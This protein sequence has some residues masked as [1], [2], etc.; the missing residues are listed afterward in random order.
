VGDQGQPGTTRYRAFGDIV[1]RGA[2][3]DQTLS[4]R[5]ERDT[6]A[7]LLAV[8]AP[9]SADR[10]L[11]E[12]WEGEGALGSLQAVVSRLRN[13]LEP[14][15]AARGENRCLVSTSAGYAIRADVADVDVW[16]FEDLAQ[17][18]VAGGDPT[19]SLRLHEE[20]EGL[21]TGTPYADCTSDAVV[22]ARARL[23]ELRASAAERAAH[24][25]LDLGRPEQVGLLLAPLAAEHPFRERLFALLALAH[26]RCGRQSEALATLRDLRTRLAD[27]LGVDPTPEV[28]RLETDLLQHSPAL[29]GPAPAP[30]PRSTPTTST[31]VASAAGPDELIG[32]DA[33][34][35]RV[36]DLLG[37]LPGGGQVVSVLGEPGI[38]K[39]RLVQEVLARAGE[40]GVTGV[41]GQCHQGDVAPALWPW[42][43]VVRALAPHAEGTDPL[44]QP[45]LDGAPVDTGSGSLRLFDAVVGLLESTA[46]S[47][48]GLVVVLEDLH[49]ADVT[50]LQLLAHVTEAP[51]TAPLLL[52]VTRRSTEEHGSDQMLVT[53]AALARAG[54]ER[55]R[56]DGLARDDVG[57]LLGRLLGRSPDDLPPTLVSTVDEAT[58]GNAFF[59]HEYARL[60]QALG[61]TDE[62]D[63]VGDLPVPEGVRDVIGQRVD[64]LPQPTR[65]LLRA[66]AVLGRDIEPQD[67]AALADQSLDEALDHLDLALA[68]G[69][70]EERRDGYTFAHALTREALYADLSAARRIRLHAKAADVLAARVGD[71]PDAAADIAHH[72]LLAVP[73]G[74]DRARTAFTS[75]GHAARV[76]LARQAPV[77]SRA[78]WLQARGVAEDL[79]LEDERLHAMLGV[80]RS[81]VRMGTFTEAPGL[82]KELAREARR[83]GHW[84]LVAAAAATFQQAGPWTWRVHGRKDEELIEVFT[85]ALDHVT[86]AAD[87][88][89]LCATLTIEHQF[90]WD[91]PTSDAYAARAI[92]AARASGDHDLLC[93]ALLVRLIASCGR[94]DLGGRSPLAEALLVERPTG[95]IE[96]TGLFHLGYALH[97]EGRVD[98][99]VAAMAEAR[100]RG[101][102]LTHSGL[103]LPLAWWEVAVAR[104][105]D[106]PAARRL[107]DEALARHLSQRFYIGTELETL[108]AVL[109][110]EPGARVDDAAIELARQGLHGQ[111]AV[112]AWSLAESG[113]LDLAADVLGECPPAHAVDYSIE[114]VW[115]LRLLVAVAL[116][117]L[118]E[119]AELLR[120]I[121]RY[122]IPLAVYGSVFHLGAFDHFRAVAHRA[123][124]DPGRALALARAAVETNRRCDIRPW[125][126]R[127]E[128]LVRDLE[129]AA[130][131]GTDEVRAGG[132]V[133]PK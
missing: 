66:A 27:E 14:G 77:E 98:E 59:V 103:D 22:A 1:V 129:G 9:V 105:H 32:R 87:E 111:R 31:Q 79:G 4:R 21:W 41:V 60:L 43:Q 118:D 123:L 126:R 17:R 36:L 5:R 100:R 67:A 96:V 58:A 75:L 102:A 53:L 88:A 40:Q 112:V 73:L 130:A 48:G 57:R 115:C 113:H 107:A 6:L 38:G 37:R 131:A 72:A 26:Y 106:D 64:R 10:L 19:E 34:L 50:S 86:D 61:G 62:L 109:H 13:V 78:L 84:D 99:A 8:R 114:A 133:A 52:L 33:P 56:L 119:V 104:D 47:Q 89:T 24:A 63:G 83:L 120:R 20:A 23:V 45:L 117:D 97:D 29:D 110:L 69:L 125:L 122:T 85:A 116:D 3:G 7:V 46:R 51:S 49:W 11:A 39:T 65:D 76:A 30:A 90:G 128:A 44:L 55:V 74:P 92:T 127:S 12:V 70:L 18:C 121:D 93:S 42:A 71:L 101:E 68:T 28:R 94:P 95:D 54:A 82:V 132:Q 124:G 16:A 108:C 91:T 2:E 81:A 80:A 15:R 25:L 35:T